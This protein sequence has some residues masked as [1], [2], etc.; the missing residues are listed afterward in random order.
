MKTSPTP[1]NQNALRAYAALL[2]H[3][4][5]FVLWIVVGLWQ[6][7]QAEA[8]HTLRHAEWRLRQMLFIAAAEQIG[9]RRARR[10][11]RANAP[12]GFRIAHREG[13]ATR[14]LTRNVLPKLARATP[15]AR[16]A[17][18]Q[19]VLD[20]FALYVA[21]QLARFMRTRPALRLVVSA[22]QTDAL[23]SAPLSRT[24]SPDS[25]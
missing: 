5:R 22:A 13:C 10:V 9:P 7:N 2:R 17:R 15:H 16:L 12:T 20:N 6:R 19:Q 14:Q 8:P 4:L 23:R 1:I 21:R 25:S 18:I 24:A 11:L 3:W